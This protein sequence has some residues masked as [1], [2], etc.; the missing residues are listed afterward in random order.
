MITDESGDHDRQSKKDNDDKWLLG[1]GWCGLA[2]HILL[3]GYM[4]AL[5][6]PE[7]GLLVGPSII[8]KAT[9]LWS[10]GGI[11]AITLLC[12]RAQ[13]RSKTAWMAAGIAI[14]ALSLYVFG[15][16]RFANT[17]MFAW[18]AAAYMAG[19]VARELGRSAWIWGILMLRFQML[20]YAILAT[21]KPARTQRVAIAAKRA[22]KKGR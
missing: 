1:A 13:L 14:L 12:F 16:G 9:Y 6:D 10:F 22:R 5:A 19:G 8:S 18:M 20:P 21:M 7:I 15:E 4:K 17:W 11:L 2:M 3:I